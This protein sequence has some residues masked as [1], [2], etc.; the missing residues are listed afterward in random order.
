MKTLVRHFQIFKVILLTYICTSVS[1]IVLFGDIDHELNDGLNWSESSNFTSDIF[2]P[3]NRTVL[4]FNDIFYQY[5]LEPLTESYIHY[6]PGRFRFSCE[7]FFSNL[8]YPVRLISNLLQ[9]KFNEAYRESL[10]FGIN[11]SVGILGINRPS[12]KFSSL[13]GL[14]DEDLG[15][16]LAVWGIPE[17]PFI[18]IP[19]L[20]PST[21]RDFPARMIGREINFLDINLRSGVSSDSEF[22]MLLNTLEILSSSE[23]IIPRYNSL[24]N[25]SID[26]YSALRSAYLQQRDREISR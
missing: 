24:R 15:Q 8:K 21:L 9:F 5:I 6:M 22:I 14:P 26:F 2:E 25:T 3:F 16:V 18:I 1:S 11:T 7:N 4:H 10:K 13:R 23:Q 20:G 12:D 17:G 19:I